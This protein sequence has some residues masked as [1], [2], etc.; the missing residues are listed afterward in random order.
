MEKIATAIAREIATE[1]DA[2]AK[3]IYDFSIESIK[4]IRE[5]TEA[6][7]LNLLGFSIADLN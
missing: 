2:L 3:E 6:C 7:D 4:E 1:N 5:V